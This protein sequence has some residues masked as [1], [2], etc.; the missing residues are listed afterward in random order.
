MRD[1]AC[2]VYVKGSHNSPLF[3]QTRKPYIP[4]SPTPASARPRNDSTDRSS[5]PTRTR[6][7]TRWRSSRMHGRR[8]WTS[9]ENRIDRYGTR[10]YLYPS[11]FS[12]SPSLLPS[13]LSSSL[14]Y[15]AGLAT[16]FSPTSQHLISRA[17]GKM[18][19]FIPPTS[20]RGS[21]AQGE[22]AARLS[23]APPHPPPRFSV[24]PDW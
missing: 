17:D 8:I 3:R 20:C 9:C 15:S 10:I 1:N 23:P 18:S 6:R 2:Q 7:G 4:T 16:C 5:K 12:F 11:A 14:V 19:V 22:S 21:I 13:P 24:V